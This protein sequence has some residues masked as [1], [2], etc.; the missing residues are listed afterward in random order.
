MQK[1][2]QLGT[3]EGG[4]QLSGRHLRCGV[5]LGNERLANRLM[6]DIPLDIYSLSNAF[7]VRIG[8]GTK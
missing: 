6:P 2:A 8:W 5:Q 7:R 1:E 3:L 4:A